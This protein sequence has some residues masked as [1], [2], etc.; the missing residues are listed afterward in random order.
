MNL[1][2]ILLKKRH[3]NNVRTD[4]IIPANAILPAKSR[5]LASSLLD[6]SML[7]KPQP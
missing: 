1:A 2:Y 6:I 4:E 3:R 5:I 7:V